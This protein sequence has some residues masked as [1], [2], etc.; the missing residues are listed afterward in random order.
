M[1]ELLRNEHTTG[2]IVAVHEQ[3]IHLVTDQGVDFELMIAPDHPVDTA[4]LE[5][6]RA[7]GPRVRVEYEGSPGAHSAHLLSVQAAEA[8]SPLR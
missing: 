5:R 4:A 6:F 8:E 1:S 3:T 2:L 7:A